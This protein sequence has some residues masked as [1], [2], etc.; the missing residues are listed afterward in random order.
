MLHPAVGLPLGI[1]TGGLS[2]AAMG[3]YRGVTMQ[4]RARKAR[5]AEAQAQAQPS[6]MG[7][8]VDASPPFEKSRSGMDYVVPSPVSAMSSTSKYLD[9]S[10]LEDSSTLS[11]KSFAVSEI[12]GSPVEPA[13]PRYTEIEGT[14]VVRRGSNKM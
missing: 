13:P 2:C 5:K 6:E 9:V 12:E 7:Q 10:E 11:G 14:Q 1:V 3:I 8:V 4:R